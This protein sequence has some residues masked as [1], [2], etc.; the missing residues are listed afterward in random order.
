MQIDRTNCPGCDSEQP[1]R[2]QARSIGGGKVEVFIACGVCPWEKMLRVSTVDIEKTRN[3]LARHI[4]L[5][6]RQLERFGAVAGQ[7]QRAISTLNHKL[8]QLEAQLAREG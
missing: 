3:R 6:R 7:T 5:S 8:A 1:F 2:P 4:A